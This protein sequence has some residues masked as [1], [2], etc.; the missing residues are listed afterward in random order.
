MSCPL[1]RRFHVPIERIYLITDLTVLALSLSYLPPVRIL[2]SLL[3]VILSGKLIGII[4]RV[5]PG[6]FSAENS[7]RN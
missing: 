6:H 2:C 3:T 7:L 1:S 4:Q 5:T